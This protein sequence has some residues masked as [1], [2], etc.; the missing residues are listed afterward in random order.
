LA[1]LISQKLA[2][3]LGQAVVVENKPGAGAIIATE[4]VARA[5]PDGYTLLL[6]ATGAMTV[7]PA[8][9]PKLAYDT[10]RDF[11]PIS[12]VATFPLLL[13]V[14]AGAPV[15]SVAELV[16]Y[17]KANPREANYAS[18]S[19]AFQLTTELFKM[20]TGAPLEHIPYKSSGEML[21]A[22]LG[23]EVLMALVD[24]L[25][26]AGHVKAG[27]T[28][29]LATTSAQRVAEYPD[30]PTMAEAGVPDLEVML[31]SGLFAPA[32][33][34][35]IILNQLER[36]LMEV[37]RLP[38]VHERLRAMAVEPNGGSARDLAQRIA[39]EIPRWAAIAKSANVRLD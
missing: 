16:S 29:V 13:C 35:S 26:V 14:N 11:A 15:K 9:Y 3:R 30:V 18:S 32:A 38:E 21:A 24:A 39:V 31:W 6:G 28:R 8:V 1:R 17:A 12:T 27:T 19:A 10:L 33:T 20:R 34:S 23:G 37:V 22:V 4:Y 7:N 25:P 5:A 2:E 36:E